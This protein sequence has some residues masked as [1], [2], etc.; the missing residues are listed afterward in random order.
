[1]EEKTT[2]RLRYG[3]SRRLLNFISNHRDQEEEEQA[4]IAVKMN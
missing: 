1:M 4:R 3:P 2:C